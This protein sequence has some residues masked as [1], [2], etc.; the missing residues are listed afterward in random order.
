MFI[1]MTTTLQPIQIVGD[2]EN[3]LGQ[4]TRVLPETPLTAI[5]ASVSPIAMSTLIAQAR[6]ILGTDK[7]PNLALLGY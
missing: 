2:S 7:L 1:G 6:P 5:P 4:A 3:H